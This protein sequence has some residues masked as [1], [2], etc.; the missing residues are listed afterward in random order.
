MPESAEAS[1]AAEVQGKDDFPEELDDGRSPLQKFRSFPRRPLTVSDLTSGAWCELQYW[2]TL[3]RL[4][5]GRRTRTAAMKQG[6]KLHQKLEDEV[7]TTVTVEVLTREDGF[8]LKLWNFI[9]GLRTLR[10]TGLTRELEVWGMVDGNLVNG[11]IDS[12]SHQ[13][14][15][16]EFEVELSQEAGE[17]K[18]QA[19]LTDFFQSK[20]PTKKTRNGPKTY[21]ADVKTRGSLKQVSTTLLRPAKIQLLLYHHFLA[22]IAA[23]QLDFYKVLRRYGLDPDEPF[24]DTFLAQMSG[25]HDEMFDDEPSSSLDSTHTDKTNKK[26]ST[27]EEPNALSYRS[28]REM[29]PLVEEEVKLAL[30]D[31][32]NSLG[33]MLRVQYIYR[34]DGREIGHYDFPVSQTA[35]RDYVSTYM[36]WWKGER[37]AKG[38]NIE[39]AFKCRTCEFAEDCTWRQGMDDERVHKVQQ[40]LRAARS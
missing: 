26:F 18:Q 16:P 24:S 22:D 36:E 8:G 29:L 21:L 5:G 3:T 2:Y 15:N 10:E 32:A 4:P 7:H 9:Q 39:E 17:Q 35:L 33:D 37:K 13:H 31:G 11:V 23:G 27:D 38:V 25:L 34:D 40:R 1:Q 28:L 30:P 6:S 14:P 12:L 19:K 20:S